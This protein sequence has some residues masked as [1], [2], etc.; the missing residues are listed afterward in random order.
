MQIGNNGIVW[1]R[2]KLSVI[3][4]VFEQAALDNMV[5]LN[6]YEQQCSCFHSQT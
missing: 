4:A 3:S 5:K 1:N 2:V 6:M